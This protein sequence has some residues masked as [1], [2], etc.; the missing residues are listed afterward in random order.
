M[1]RWHLMDQDIEITRNF[2]T[3]LKKIPME[4]SVR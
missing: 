4:A 3:S 2:L 1:K